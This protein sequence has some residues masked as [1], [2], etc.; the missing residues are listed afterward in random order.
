MEPADFASLHSHSHMSILD[1]FSTIDEYLD[2]VEQNGQK[3]LGLTDHGNGYALYDFITKARQRSIIPVPGVEA[4]LAPD[5]PEGAKAKHQI[6]YGKNG[7]KSGN[8]DVS[9]NGAYLH[10]TI[11]AVNNTGMHNLFKLISL[12]NQ[13][14]NFYKAPRMDFEMLAEHSDGLVVATGCPSSEISTR[15]LLGQDD[16]AYEYANRLKEVFG[17]RLFVEIMDHNMKIDLERKLLPKQLDLSKKLNLPLLATIDSHYAKREHARH[18]EELL[19]SQSGARM[20][21]K[22]Y[23]EGGPRFAFEGNEYYLKST[24]E[25]SNLFPEEDYPNALTNTM[26]IAEMAQDINLE[27][28]PNLKAKAVIPTGYTEESYLKHLIKIG[29]KERYGNADREVKQEAM[30]RVKEEFEVLY[31]SDFIGYI[32]TVHEYLDWTKKNYATYDDNNNVIAYPVGVGRG[33]FL[34]GNKVRTGKGERNIEK[35]GEPTKSGKPFTVRTVLTHDGTQKNVENFFIYN[36]ENE[37]CIEIT[38]ENKKVI[39]CTSDHKIFLKGKGY[40]E[41]RK[42]KVGNELLG[43]KKFN[44]HNEFKIKKIRQFKY[45]GK[46]Y[47]IQVADTHN[48]TISD[49]TVHN[50]VGGSIIAFLLGIS[51]VDPIRYDLLFSRFLSAGRGATYEI[52]YDDGTTEEII[53]SEKKKVRN[54]NGTIKYKYIH[55]LVEGDEIID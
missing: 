6:F 20:S 39:T 47:D 9:A 38:L 2:M 5:N 32:L 53:V 42:L 25:M 22:T 4:Y 11:W 36:V 34:P 23:N 3:A 29:L 13:Q 52:S 15:F 54:S 14:E 19:C 12:S 41:A 30:K 31:S 49:V 17:D 26:L 40:V 48:Y 46:V 37:D 16:K 24:E 51:E 43:A 33:C 1:G 35:M 55:Q 45:S 28:D 10:Q 7:V 18:H 44:V 27:F 50:S 21:D 8:N